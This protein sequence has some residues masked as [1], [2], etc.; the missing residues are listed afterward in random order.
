MEENAS[1]GSAASHA[2]PLV[3]GTHHHALRRM[4]DI[5]QRAVEVDDGPDYVDAWLEESFGPAVAGFIRTCCTSFLRWE[6]L[7]LLCQNRDGVPFRTLVELTGS[8]SAAASNELQSL[9]SLGIIGFRPHGQD[10]AYY[11]DADSPLSPALHVAIRGFSDNQAF[12]FAL[13]YSIVR[14]NILQAELD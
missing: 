6:L 1:Q 14:A 11:L 5:R 12:R 4:D 7:R 8:N 3:T 9:A 2:N 10:I 13:I